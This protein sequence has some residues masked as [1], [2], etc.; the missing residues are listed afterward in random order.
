MVV[1]NSGCCVV[2]I[3]DI[4]DSGTVVVDGRAIVST[5]LDV[6][7]DVKEIRKGGA[8]DAGR[9]AG[10]LPSTVDGSVGSIGPI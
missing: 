2:D 8:A 1:V 3:P 6:C 10:S 9:Y 5:M 4:V 7:M